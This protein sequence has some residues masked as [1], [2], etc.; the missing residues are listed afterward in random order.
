VGHATGRAILANRDEL[1][2]HLLRAEDSL[3][4]GA[5]QDAY[6]E[7]SSIAGHLFA[8]KPFAPVS[9]PGNWRSLLL[10]WVSGEELPPI[11]GDPGEG[12]EFIQDGLVYRLV[13]ATE[14]V[15]VLGLAAG[16]EELQS[17]NGLVALSLTYGLPTSQGCVLAQAGLRSRRMVMRLVE[18]FPLAF[19]D[20]ESF[21]RWMTE[22]PNSTGPVLWRE[23]EQTLV[24]NEFVKRWEAGTSGS[25][26]ETTQTVDVRWT[27]AIPS[28]GRQLRL[29]HNS[30]T[31]QTGVYS[32]ELARLGSLEPP[33]PS[34]EEGDV[35]VRAI[36]AQG[37]L[38]IQRFS[39]P[40]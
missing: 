27:S 16:M 33:M 31:G 1:V 21:Q 18:D 3:R 17:V 15:R 2:G 13:W 28:D 12:I 34:V 35:T 38:V 5:V 26:K 25:W 9:I 39:S 6:E 4:R 32:S 14:A 29:L 30:R 8:I 37:R 19:T 10:R 11:L 24:W 23:R 22:L 20:R 40:D 36:D 7:I